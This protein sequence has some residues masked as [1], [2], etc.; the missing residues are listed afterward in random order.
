MGGAGGRDGLGHHP[1]EVSGAAADVENPVP[2]AGSAL[3]GQPPVDTA[4][5]ATKVH[6]GEE[7]VARS[8][9]DE[10]AGRAGVGFAVPKAR[11]SHH[12]SRRRNPAIM[13][14]TSRR[15]AGLEG[16]LL[17]AVRA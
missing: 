6:G 8:V 10:Y 2:W 1:G 12:H 3:G 4:S 11:W 16:R 14:V 5:A 9:C 7:V 13:T 15:S 17:E